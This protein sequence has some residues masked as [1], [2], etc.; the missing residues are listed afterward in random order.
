M[1]F[2]VV[3]RVHAFGHFSVDVSIWEGPYTPQQEK[4]VVV[5]SESTQARRKAKERS[6]AQQKSLFV[7]ECMLHYT[8]PKPIDAV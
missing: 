8:K 3:V 7:I 5:T 6:T 1:T 4:L 2:T